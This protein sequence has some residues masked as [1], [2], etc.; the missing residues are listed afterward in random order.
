MPFQGRHRTYAIFWPWDAEPFVCTSDISQMAVSKAVAQGQTAKLSLFPRKVNT[1]RLEIGGRNNDLGYLDVLDPGDWLF[2]FV[3]PNDGGTPEPLFLGMLDSVF[4]QRS[5]S[6]VGMRSQSVEVSA[7]G[8]EKAIQGTNAITSPHV[9]SSINTATLLN[10]GPFGWITQTR[11]GDTAANARGDTNYTLELPQL[12]ETLV[13]LFLRTDRSRGLDPSVDIQLNRARET[14]DTMSRGVSPLFGGQFELPGTGIPLWDFIKMKFEDLHQRTYID[15]RMFLNGVTRSLSQLIDQMSNPLINE[16][17]YDVRRVNN[18]HLS[19][20]DNR[21]IRGITGGYTED[22]VRE[23]VRVARDTDNDLATLIEDVAPYMVFRRRPLSPQEIQELD[24][25]TIDELEFVDLQ[26][27]KS[28]SD[29]NNMVALEFPQV[30]SQL[31]R[32][33]SGFP[34]FTQYEAGCMES[35]RRHG[36][37]FY[38]DQAGAWDSRFSAPQ[39]DLAIGR[40]WEI[41]LTASGLDNVALYTG[42]GTLPYFRRD[43]FLGGK[44]KIMHHT[45]EGISHNPVD[46]VYYV[47]SLDYQ[48][49]PST[50]QF[51]TKI[52]LSRGYPAGDQRPGMD[53]P[54]VISATG[55]RDWADDVSDI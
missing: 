25:P 36:V 21:L 23:F 8:W 51:T 12:I 20:M 2:V 35:I 27:G 42:S 13:A 17:F 19:H 30:S 10:L 47:D 34:G 33:Q 48:T 32:V 4:S 16:I 1:S 18:D 15:P 45:S 52:A 28:D 44:V 50:G 37:R 49:D 53:R 43:V 31:M 38:Q 6:S 29:L 40:D 22:A 41:R 3:D 54:D 11:E 26:L 24:G 55:N 14:N 46:R 39:P 7:T 9:S 5:V